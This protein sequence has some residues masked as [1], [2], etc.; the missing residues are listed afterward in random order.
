MVSMVGR[1]AVRMCRSE[2][3]FWS[4]LSDEEKDRYRRLAT[5]AIETLKFPTR[6]MLDAGRQTPPEFAL[7]P[8]TADCDVNA[9]PVD[10]KHSSTYLRFT[11]MLDAALASGEQTPLGAPDGT[12]PGLHP[13]MTGFDSSAEHQNPGPLAG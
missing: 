13:G 12:A 8:G 4:E 1:I 2:H 9:M 11:A 5:I 3:R 6:V 7:R 10:E